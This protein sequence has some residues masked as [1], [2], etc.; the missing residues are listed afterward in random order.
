MLAIFPEVE[1][2][3]LS[4]EVLGELSEMVAIVTEEESWTLYFDGSSTSKGGGAGVVLINPNGQ[5][6]ALIQARLSMHE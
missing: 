2:S 6:T 3:T 4:K 1:E 5:A